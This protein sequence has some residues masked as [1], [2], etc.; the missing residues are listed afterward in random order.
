MQRPFLYEKKALFL[1]RDGIIIKMYYDRNFGIIDTPL[2]VSQIEFVPGIFELLRYAK[3]L[4]YL[5][6]L[7]SN[8][9]GVGIKKI[10][11]KRYNEIKAYISKVLQKHGITLNG[12]YY[13]MHHPYASILKYRK[14]C[15]DRK[16]S[17]DLLIKASKDFN[18]DLKKSWMI[19]DGIYD[20]IAGYEA[21][22]KTVLVGNIIE[23]EYLRILEEKLGN[24]R[25]T[26]L[27]KN[28]KEIKTLF[29]S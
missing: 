4:G 13:C 27:V 7:I 14:E 21:G 24:I 18:I 17:T 29:A 2:S 11:L 6:I 10:S 9:P 22:C 12:Q 3:Q 5:L 8:Q 1:D 25:P 16:P 19:G 20:I 26:F 15:P 28:I 23:A